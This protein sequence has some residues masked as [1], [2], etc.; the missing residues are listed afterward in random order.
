M[1]GPGQLAAPRERGVEVG[2][3]DDRESADVLLALGERAVGHEHL[4]VLEPDH[5]G[6]AGRVQPAGEDPDAGRH[7]LVI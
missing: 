2:R 6:R 1:A 3:L 5:R 4:A 7:H